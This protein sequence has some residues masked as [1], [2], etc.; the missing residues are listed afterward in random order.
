MIQDIVAEAF[1]NYHEHVENRF[2]EIPVGEFLC[3]HDKTLQ[4]PIGDDWKFTFV[5]ESHIMKT[6]S[7]CGAK[8]LKSVYGPKTAELQEMYDLKAKK[9]PNV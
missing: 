4:A 9:S 3:V 1:K 8:C 6:A 2:G 5:I 7:D